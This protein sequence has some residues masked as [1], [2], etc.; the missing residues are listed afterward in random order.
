IHLDDDFELDIVSVDGSVTEKETGE[1]VET[2]EDNISEEDR[3]NYLKS[4][5][6]AK[7]RPVAKKLDLSTFRVTKKVVTTTNVFSSTEAIAATWPLPYSGTV[8]AMKS[9][10]GAELE[11][12]R[13]YIEDETPNN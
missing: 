5:I 7:I 9:W 10:T 2:T 3:L 1:E 8:I 13:G 11:T 12:L 6:S 4:L